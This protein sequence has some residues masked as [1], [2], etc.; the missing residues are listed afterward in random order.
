MSKK[1]GLLPIF[2]V[3][4]IVLTVITFWYFLV[5]KKEIAK[6]EFIN[7]EIK[8]IVF[9]EIYT[10]QEKGSM[11]EYIK[12]LDEE[13]YVAIPGTNAPE[14]SFGDGE[15][16]DIIFIEGK[17]SYSNGKFYLGKSVKDTMLSFYDE[18]GLNSNRY[19]GIYK[20]A[21]PSTID[22]ETG[23]IEKKEKQWVY[24]RNSSNGNVEYPLERS[25]N[26]IPNSMDEF[27]KKYKKVDEVSSSRE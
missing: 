22:F 12:F 2:L 15:T 13:N 18:K 23:S 5:T 4:I 16:Y 25:K 19:V 24:R 8:E 21:K 17:Y 10:F 20:S 11:P 27:L 26:D 14:D 9:G 3:T 6:N 7:S 1:T